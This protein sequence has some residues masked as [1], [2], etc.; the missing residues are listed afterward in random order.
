[1]GFEWIDGHSNKYAQALNGKIFTGVSCNTESIRRTNRSEW[2][3]V[4]TLV[5]SGFGT[6]VAGGD[7]YDINPGCVMF[8]HPKMDYQFELSNQCF[9]RR[10]YL[11]LPNEIF[12]LL[13]EV[14]P[15]LVNVPPVF[16]VEDIHRF[17]D[18][19][20]HV[21]ES[22]E[23]STDENF[24][25]LL[26]VVERYILHVLSSYLLEGKAAQLCR[27]KAQLEMDFTSSLEDIAKEYSMS[28]NTFRKNFAQTYKIS[29]Q[30]YRLRCKV[31]KAKQLLSMGYHCSEVAD[32][33]SYP[34][35][36]TF[37][38]QFKAIAGVTPREFRK[39]HIL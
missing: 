17:F 39:V 10:C 2:G 14:H 27:A 1:M 13:G 34:D 28:Y 26:P 22:V 24:F 33:L 29:P 5:I 9:H 21:Y 12:F 32:M 37:S 3:M 18:D 25:S 15:N 4:I 7:R 8:R 6:L 35:L 23:K 19:F 30:Q 38:H 11:V 20:L 16:D 36:Y 31:E